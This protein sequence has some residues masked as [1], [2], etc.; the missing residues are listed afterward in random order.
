M[1]MYLEV[2]IGQN[3]SGYR[4]L[5]ERRVPRCHSAF[6]DPHV[7]R[8]LQSDKSDEVGRAFFREN[9]PAR[10]G[11]VGLESPTYVGIDALPLLDPLVIPPLRAGE[12]LARAGDLLIGLVEH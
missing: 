9:R 2:F 7:G 10:A 1:K 4:R 12:N 5:S 8:T 11:L 3:L 6:R